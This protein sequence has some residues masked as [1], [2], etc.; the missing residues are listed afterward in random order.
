MSREGSPLVTGR[1]AEIFEESI[2]VI[3]Q[4]QWSEAVYIVMT[5]LPMEL[6]AAR[7]FSA[8]S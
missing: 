5:S 1:T 2:R 7:S 4:G 3:S 8:L 6:A